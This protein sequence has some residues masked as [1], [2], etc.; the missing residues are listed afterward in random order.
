M[1]L[2]DIKKDMPDSEIK[3]LKNQIAM[4]KAINLIF[5]NVVP[6]DRPDEEAE[7]EA[8]DDAEET[9]ASIEE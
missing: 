4:E 7:A 6:V 3:S 1:S 2:E 9:E 8:E 5:D